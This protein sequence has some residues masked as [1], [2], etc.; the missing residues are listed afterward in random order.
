MSNLDYPIALLEDAGSRISYVLQVTGVNQ[1]Y[2]MNQ[3]DG[4]RKAVG[5][6]QEARSKEKIKEKIREG[7]K[8]FK[9]EKDALDFK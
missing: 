1:T 2:R 9:R 7:E 6:L 4:I 5:I 8:R 3:L